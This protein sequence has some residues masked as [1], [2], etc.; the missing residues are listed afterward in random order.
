M[1]MSWPALLKAKDNARAVSNEL[2]RMLK[3]GNS[4]SKRDIARHKETI[5][6]DIDRSLAIIQEE[7]DELQANLKNHRKY[8]EAKSVFIQRH[9]SRKSTS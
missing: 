3:N 7:L 5:L 2:D 4:L 6:A 8:F 1:I 9:Y